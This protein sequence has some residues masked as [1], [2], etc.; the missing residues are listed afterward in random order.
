MNWKNKFLIALISLAAVSSSAQAS[1]ANPEDG[2]EYMTLA[3]AQPTDAKDKVEV[4]EFFFY[5]CPHCNMLDP[6][7]TAW[8]KKQGHVISF[9]RIPVDFG[10]GQAVLTKLYYTLESMGKLEAMHAKIFEE[11]HVKRRPLMRDDQVISFV[12]ANGID[13]KQFEETSKSFG[14][15]SKIS[16]AKAAQEAYN[17]DSVPMIFVG[18]RY[19]TSPALVMGANKKMTEAQSEQAL[20]KVLDAL[21]IKVQKEQK[22]KK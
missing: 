22:L 9:K 5:T 17:V 14:V 2:K 3:Q 12:T 18:G 10:Q 11:L 21:V 6:Y 19:M 20:M 16:R 15:A 4:T 7:L 13:K 8:V 1:L